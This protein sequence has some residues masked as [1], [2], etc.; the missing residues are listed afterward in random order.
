MF[1]FV[2]DVDGFRFRIEEN[3]EINIDHLLK[4]EPI[5][6]EDLNKAD[7][8]NDDVS[9][10]EFYILFKDKNV[11]LIQKRVR[12]MINGLANAGLASSQASNDDLRSI[13]DNFASDSIDNIFF[14][15]WYFLNKKFYKK[16][17]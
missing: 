14:V 2:Y 1:P 16:N 4:K 10:I 3:E 17:F 6:N 5:I 9:D 12:L 7:K 11:E 13:L 15:L 8:F